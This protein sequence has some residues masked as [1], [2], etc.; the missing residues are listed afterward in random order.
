MAN[1]LA[2]GMAWLNEQL[3][4]QGSSAVTY[5]RGAASVSLNATLGRHVPRSLGGLPDNEVD[6]FLTTMTFEAADLVLS[7]ALTLPQR[8]DTVSYTAN[9][10]AFTFDVLPID[11]ERMWKES[12]A[13]GLRIEINLKL[14][15]R[16]T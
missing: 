5:T 6:T 9:G 16:S 8:G 2:T 14:R 10:V 12:D 3:N 15:S 7:S 13:F 4:S 1:L 11:G